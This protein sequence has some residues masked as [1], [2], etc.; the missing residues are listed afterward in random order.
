VVP[1]DYTKLEAETREA[2][3]KKLELAGWSSQ[4]RRHLDLH[5]SQNLIVF[6]FSDEISA[7]RTDLQYY[8]AVDAHGCA[9]VV[10]GTSPGTG[11]GRT[12][13]EQ[14]SRIPRATTVNMVATGTDIKPNKKCH[15]MSSEADALWIRDVKSQSYYEQMKGRG[16][17]IISRDELHTNSSGT[18]LVAL[19]CAPKGRAPWMARDKVTLGKQMVMKCRKSSFRIAA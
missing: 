4:D 17:R 6:E 13:Q 5:N 16:T 12:T 3:D 8:T 15:V 18:N 7:F 1:P 19:Q 10:G 9:N 2:I 14:L 11:D